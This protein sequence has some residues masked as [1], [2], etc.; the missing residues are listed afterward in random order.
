MTRWLRRFHSGLTDG[1]TLVCFPHAGGSASF[2]QPVS[3]ALRESVPVLA[4]QYPGRQERWQERLLPSIDELA[5]GAHAALRS[6]GDQPLAFFGH[7]MGAVVAYEVALRMRRDGHPGPTVL[8]AS[9]RPAPSRQRP[10]ERIHQRDDDGLLDEVRSLGGTD[11]RVFEDA[12]LR[13]MVL[14]AL[15]SDYQAVDTYRPQPGRKLACDI[16]VLVGAGDHKVT[17][18][19]AAAWR[20]HTTGTTRVLTFPGGHFYLIAQQSEVLRAITTELV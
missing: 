8:F 16:V 5:D 4:V 9:G 1:T 15:R 20:E 13:T 18:D 11:A 12:D 10:S 17:P 7:S 19:E 3:A 6:V 14:P 2:F